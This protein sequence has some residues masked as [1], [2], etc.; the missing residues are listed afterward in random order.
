M[1]RIA[2]I[3]RKEKKMGIL[4]KAFD[5]LDFIPGWKTNLGATGMVLVYL[6]QWA[7]LPAS[8]VVPTKEVLLAILT[9]G[10]TMKA[11]RAVKP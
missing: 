2:D 5:F 7:G 4:W 8:Y 3:D 1:M 6:L 10:L 11:A 9:Y